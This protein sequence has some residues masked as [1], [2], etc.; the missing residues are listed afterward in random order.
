MSYD[1]EDMY[2]DVPPTKL[3][4][5]EEKFRKVHM[6]PFWCWFADVCFFHMIEKRFYGIRVKNKEN[7]EKRNPNYANIAYA[8]HFNWWDGIT[9]YYICKKTFKSSIRMMIEEANKFPLFTKAGAFPVNKKSAQTAMK[10]LNYAT[11]LLE[12]KGVT[13][14]TFPQGIVKPT[15]FRPI[16]F[17][18]GMIYMTEKVAKKG[19]YNLV[20]YGSFN[21]VWDPH[22][23]FIVLIEVK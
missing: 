2:S 19:F 6:V 16:D 22:Q 13:L 21:K 17:Q 15:N 1:E 9:G 11:E 4:N 20:F 18:T 8:P 7:Y 10:A 5:R 23:L 3:R 12:D 14:W